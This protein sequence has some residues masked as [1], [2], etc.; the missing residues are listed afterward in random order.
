MTLGLEICKFGSALIIASA[1]LSRTS[2]C[3]IGTCLQ[4]QTIPA[5]VGSNRNLL[6][7]LASS[8]SLHFPAES[9]VDILRVVSWSAYTWRERERQ[10]ERRKGKERKDRQTERE[11]ESENK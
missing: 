6:N 8:L 9:E 11:R 4:C 2:M 1:S 10:K 3:M 7:R 5:P